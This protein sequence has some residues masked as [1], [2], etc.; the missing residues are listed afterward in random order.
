MNQI[1]NQKLQNDYH[2]MNLKKIKNLQGFS[3][4]E[5]TDIKQ[6]FQP[7]NTENGIRYS[8]A[9][10][11]IN[12]GK[13][14]KSHIMKTSEVYYIVQGTGIMHVNDESEIVSKDMSVYIPPNSK[15]CLENNGDADLIALCIVDPAWKKEDEI[16]E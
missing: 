6:I 3:A 14:S 15:Q 4:G 10:C 5:G 13:S 9:H 12:P 8:I 16:S 2:K 11:T 1:S 7:T